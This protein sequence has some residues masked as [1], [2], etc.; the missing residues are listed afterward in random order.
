MWIKIAI[1]SVFFTLLGCSSNNI[2]E[3]NAQF[4]ISNTMHQTELLNYAKAEFEKNNP[5]L[6]NFR[7]MFEEHDK[8]VEV[9][10]YWD[11]NVIYTVGVDGVSTEDIVQAGD[12][13]IRVSNETLAEILE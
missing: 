2:T 4:D 6:Y 1:V 11:N 9:K 5:N 12:W 8:Y 3:D 13:E 10:F 7:Y